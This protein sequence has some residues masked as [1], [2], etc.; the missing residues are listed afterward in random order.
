MVLFLWLNAALIEENAARKRFAKLG[1]FRKHNQESTWNNQENTWNE[2]DTVK[3]METSPM[4]KN[5]N[6]R[7]VEI[8]ERDK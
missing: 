1:A 2:G 4:S 5:K 6:L 7:L 3:I 8:I